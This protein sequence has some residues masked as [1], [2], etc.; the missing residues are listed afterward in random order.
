M[1]VGNSCGQGEFVSARQAREKHMEHNH[2][3]EYQVKIV[4]RDGTEELSG[5]MNNKD[6][7][8]LAMAAARRLQGKAYWLQ[9][10]NVLCPNCLD[11][12]QRILELSRISPLH[13]AVHTTLI[14][15]GQWGVGRT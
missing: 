13:G 12:E 7:V 14:I 6:Q 15:C 8:P 4:R 10:R 5:W 2:G 1:E 3:S 11:R 9:E